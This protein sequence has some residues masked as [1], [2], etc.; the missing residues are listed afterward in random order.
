M[1]LNKK[2]SLMQGKASDTSNSYGRQFQV[3]PLQPFSN[4]SSIL[5]NGLMLV[6]LEADAPDGGVTGQALKYSPFNNCRI[7]NNSS[8]DIICYPNQ[9]RAQGILIPSSTSTTLDNSAV[10]GFSSVLIENVGSGT[11][12]SKQIRVLLWKD[13]VTSESIIKRL[14]QGLFS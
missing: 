9:Q 13:T 4:A 5:A 6:D 8:N 10:K 7:V 3:S 1:I 11:I 12:T 14:H 2:L